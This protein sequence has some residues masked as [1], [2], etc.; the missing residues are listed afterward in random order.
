M[1]PG[2]AL[3]T[4]PIL[5]AATPGTVLIG[6][7]GGYSPN[8]ECHWTV[9]CDRGAASIDFESLH[10]ETG[11]DHIYAFD[12]SDTE[13][14]EIGLPRSGTT[15]SPTKPPESSSCRW[16]AS[17]PDAARWQVPLGH[18]STSP[19]M[20][21]VFTADGELQGDGFVAAVACTPTYKFS[22]ERPAACGRLSSL[23]CVAQHHS[24]AAS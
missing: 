23:G 5:D 19:S 2:P 7:E 17:E 4:Q 13:G 1:R 9:S 8:Q 6:I 24:T 22:G 18:T 12:G 21:V 16:A 15:V 3:L 14:I 20:H 10:T 11:F